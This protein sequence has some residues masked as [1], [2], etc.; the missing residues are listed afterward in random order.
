M[1]HILKLIIDPATRP[2]SIQKLGVI[3]VA[4]LEAAA[5]DSL[6][7]WFAENVWKK[8]TLK[9]LF[10]VAKMEEKYKQNIIRGF[11]LLNSR[12]RYIVLTAL[13]QWPPPRSSS[14]QTT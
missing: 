4:E 14:R 5:I 9:E 12:K 6:K 3:T 13:P 2:P 10:R 7:A 11:L 1:K 8:P